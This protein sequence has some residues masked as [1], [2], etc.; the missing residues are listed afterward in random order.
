MLRG[1]P[2]L[3]GAWLVVVVV[4]AA[5]GCPAKLPYYNY[6]AEPDPRKAEYVLGA[7]DVLRVTVWH[8][9]DLSGE[10]VVRPDGTISMP[11]VG[12]LRAAGRTPSAL[13]DEL[14]QRLAKFIK[15]EAATVTVAVSAINSYRFVV[16]GN[17]ERGG[18]FSSNHFVTVTEAISLA[19]GPN[20]YATAEQTVIIRTDPARGV[21][22]IPIDYPSIL[23]GT[24]PEH[25]LPI[26]AGDTIYVP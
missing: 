19:G 22:R 5:A 8:N 10:V 7:S 1:A 11:L 3:R 15:D 21:R 2:L 14:T 24:H 18:S 9:P 25:D 4:V 12:D 6:A 16:S 13:R 23:K 17:V 20:R 26:L